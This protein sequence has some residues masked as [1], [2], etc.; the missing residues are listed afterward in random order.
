MEAGKAPLSKVLVSGGGRCNVMH[1]PNKDLS[2]IVKA[3]PRG[4]R[5]LIS[6]YTKVFGPWDTLDWFENHGL[7][8]K[9]EQDGRMF[10]TSDR[11]RLLYAIY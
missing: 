9:A 7:E 3:Y 4:Q 10:P 11:Y 8:L 6:P 5:E 2:L 1:N